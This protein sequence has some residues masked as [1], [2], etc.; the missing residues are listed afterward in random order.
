MR[1]FVSWVGVLTIVW[2]TAAVAAA[3]TKLKLED[4]TRVMKKAGSVQQTLVKAI[5]AGDQATAKTQVATLK[6]GIVDAQTFWSTNKRTDAVDISKTVLTK[7]GVLENIINAPKIDS[8]AAL[9][10]I[11][12]MNRS[13]TDCHKVYRTTDEDGHYILKPGSIPGY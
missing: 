9:S 13:C 10:A 3:Q 8:A 4:V 7:L 11:Q 6:S 5:Q 2:A 1:R 12:D